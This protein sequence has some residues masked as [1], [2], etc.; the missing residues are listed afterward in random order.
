MILDVV[1]HGHPKT[2]FTC[3]SLIS[4]SFFKI[5]LLKI[6]LI[7]IYKMPPHLA[8]Y[9]IRALCILTQ[10]IQLELDTGRLLPQSTRMQMRSMMSCICNEVIAC[11]PEFQFFEYFNLNISALLSDN[12][13]NE[14]ASCRY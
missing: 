13:P 11:Q 10:K 2:I 4:W 5:F 14:V 1:K 3:I 8:C 9:L 6:G 12:K 7:S